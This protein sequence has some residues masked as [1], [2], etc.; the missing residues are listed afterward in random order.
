MKYEKIALGFSVETETDTDNKY[1]IK[2]T[3]GIHPTDGIAPNFSKDIVVISD[4]S[5]TGFDVDKQREQAIEDF[6]QKINN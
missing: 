1:S 5:Q 6:M 2:I 4:N 3:I